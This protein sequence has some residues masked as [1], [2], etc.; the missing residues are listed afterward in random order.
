ML[1]LV[2]FHP[3]FLEEFDE[4]VVGGNWSQFPKPEHLEWLVRADHELGFPQ[5]I[6]INEKPTTIEFRE[7]YLEYGRK[8]ISKNEF[9]ERLKKKIK[10]AKE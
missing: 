4:I 10:Q 8:R 5:I 1:G 9:Y 7:D 6:Y 3:I 2:Q